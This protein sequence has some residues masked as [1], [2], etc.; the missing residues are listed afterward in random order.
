MT[1]DE[2]VEKYL[3]LEETESTEVAEFKSK[4]KKIKETLL[5]KKYTDEEKLKIIEKE[6]GLILLKIDDVIKKSKS[7]NILYNISQ[8]IR[9]FKFV[10]LVAEYSKLAYKL[11]EQDPKK[12]KKAYGN[13]I[14]T[15]SKLNDFVA[16]F[17]TKYSK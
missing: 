3:I 16:Y 7:K 17:K 2:L 13:A 6:L 11:Y 1:L 5:G 4:I 8:T 9:I 12:Y 14:Y 15:V 10:N